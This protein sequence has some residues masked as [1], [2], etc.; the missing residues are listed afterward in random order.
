MKMIAVVLVAVIAVMAAAGFAWE[1]NRA[2][3][4]M[5]DALANANLQLKKAKDDTLAIKAETA[6]LQKEFD[7][8]KLAVEQ[9]RVE[10]AT[11]Q[12]TIAAEKAYV[13]SLREELMKAKE[14]MASMSRL[15]S[16]QTAPMQVVPMEPTIQRQQPFAIK[17]GPSGSAIGAGVRAK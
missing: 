10:V 13:V 9:L 2:L 11:A 14:Q 16:V 5:E 15:R 17:A 12:S 1:R 7:A 4:E 8:Q 3:T 6:A